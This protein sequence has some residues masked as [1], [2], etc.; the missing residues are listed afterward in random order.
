MSCPEELRQRTQQFAL[1][2]IKLFQGLPRSEEARILGRQVLR[3]GT[4]LAANHRAVCRARSRAEFIS[5][6]GTVIE[7]AD[8]T[9]FWLELL[10][11]AGLMPK[12]RIDNLLAEANQLVAIF[13][14]SRKTAK[15]GPMAQS[16]ITRSSITQ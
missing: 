10:V 6:I 16:S 9:V 15:G 3:S 12:A 2:V 1:R 4:S 13:V 8:E 11:E 14:A 7:E 5:K